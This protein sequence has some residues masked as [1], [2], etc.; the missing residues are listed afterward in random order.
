MKVVCLNTHIV[1]LST[2][3]PIE[4]GKCMLE[5]DRADSTDLVALKP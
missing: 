5:C 3:V 4:S 1:Q 2:F